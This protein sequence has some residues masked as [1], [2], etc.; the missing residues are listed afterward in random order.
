MRALAF[1]TGGGLDFWVA[2]RPLPRHRPALVARRARSRGRA[3]T[4]FRS[5]ALH[6]PEGDGGRG[7]NRSFSGL[8]RHLRARSHPAAGRRPS[9]ARPPAVHAGAAARLRRGLG[10]RPSRVLFCEGEVTQARYGGEAL[11]LRRRIEAPIGGCEI[12]IEDTVENLGAEPQRAGHALPLQPRLPGDPDRHGGAPRGE[13]RSSARSRCPT[14]PTARPRRAG[15]RPAIVRPA[16]SARRTAPAPCRCEFSFATD[17]LPHLQV[18]RDLRPHAGDRGGRALHQRADAGRP[19]R[20]RAADRPGR[21]APLRGAGHAARA[22]LARPTSP[23]TFRREFGP[24][25]SS[26]RIQRRLHC[27]WSP[28]TAG[29][30]PSSR[31]QPE[32]NGL[33]V[34]GPGAAVRSRRQRQSPALASG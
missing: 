18:W 14:P 12:R 1:S 22:R 28:T 31:A 21:G 27:Q 24:G 17:T 10:S 4:G 2:V 26:G 15:P 19:Q 25:G 30:G 8:P 29:L 16:S 9:A 20:P 7:F 5:P 32:G 13:R 34:D 23:R 11:R 33:P 6:D 3:P